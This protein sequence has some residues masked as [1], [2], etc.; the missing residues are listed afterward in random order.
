[1]GKGEMSSCVFSSSSSRV[2]GRFSKRFISSSAQ[3]IIELVESIFG[4]KDQILS[5]K[6]KKESLKN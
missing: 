3:T 6:K 5:E 2:S 4:I 1:M